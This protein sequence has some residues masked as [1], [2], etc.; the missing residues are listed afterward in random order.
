MCLCPE[1]GEG[2]SR[3]NG[4]AGVLRCPPTK[5]FSRRSPISS[6]QPWKRDWEVLSAPRRGGPRATGDE[7]TGSQSPGSWGVAGGLRTAT[8]GPSSGRT[9]RETRSSTAMLMLREKSPQPSPTR[10]P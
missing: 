4:R 3:I 10:P 2:E 5:S 8:W 9:W 6:S 7:D 1:A